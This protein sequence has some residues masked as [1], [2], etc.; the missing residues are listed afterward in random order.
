MDVT[1]I[2][3]NPRQKLEKQISKK[4]Q[5]VIYCCLSCFLYLHM[6][7]IHVEIFDHADATYRPAVSNTIRLHYN[8]CSYNHFSKLVE[9]VQ[10]AK[11]VLRL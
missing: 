1:I 7:R 9:F 8:T 11:L 3:N 2:V 4:S 10:L 5:N 6:I